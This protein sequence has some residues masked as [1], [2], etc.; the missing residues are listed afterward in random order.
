MDNFMSV[1]GFTVTSV[2]ILGMI[3]TYIAAKFSAFQNLE[4]ILVVTDYIKDRL[5]SI[6]Y[7][8]MVQ[9]SN[10]TKKKG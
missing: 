10:S 5:I 9:R 8:L 1:V 3:V 6:E 7:D 2:F 4:K